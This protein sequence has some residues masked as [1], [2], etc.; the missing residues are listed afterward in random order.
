MATQNKKVFNK[1]N[2]LEPSERK[3]EDGGTFDRRR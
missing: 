3:Y 1:V 2:I